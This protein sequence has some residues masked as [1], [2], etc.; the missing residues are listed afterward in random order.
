M[1]DTQSNVLVLKDT[2]GSYI[3]LPEEVLAQYRLPHAHDD[4][5]ERLLTEA[6]DVHGH[7]DELEYRIIGTIFGIAGL[8]GVEM[9]L[10]LGTLGPGLH[11]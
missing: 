1:A 6:D 2:A 11:R 9:G 4:E 8:V 7:L 10:R 5:V 3:A